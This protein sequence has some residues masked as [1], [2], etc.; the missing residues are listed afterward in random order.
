MARRYNEEGADEIT[1]SISPRVRMTGMTIVHVVEQ[2]A[3]EGFHSADR[4]WRN[5]QRG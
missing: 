4:R 2:V 1:F 5:T 3:G